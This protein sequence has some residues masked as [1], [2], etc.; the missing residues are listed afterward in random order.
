M[1]PISTSLFLLSTR[2]ESFRF[3]SLPGIPA[4]GEIKD[5]FVPV[6]ALHCGQKSSL[7]SYSLRTSD[8]QTQRES[9]VKIDMPDRY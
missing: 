8:F 3:S 1:S 5:V 6:D 2:D 4:D 7:S 9:G